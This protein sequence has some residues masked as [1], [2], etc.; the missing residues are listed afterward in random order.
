MNY[1][2]HDE[3]L[4]HSTSL[5]Q[6]GH[7]YLKIN[8]SLAVFLLSAKSSEDTFIMTDQ[9][10]QSRN[11]LLFT[12]EHSNLNC[13]FKQFWCTTISSKANAL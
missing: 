7:M 8:F 13:T 6:S 2:R 3:K 12:N 10:T 1:F 9:F 4:F 11:G 5:E